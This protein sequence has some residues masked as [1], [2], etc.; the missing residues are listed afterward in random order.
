M[1]LVALIVPQPAHFF[2]YLKYLSID[3]SNILYIYNF[4]IT[5]MYL[6]VNNIYINNDACAIQ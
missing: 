5:V 4:I 1:L 3:L 2:K 6:L